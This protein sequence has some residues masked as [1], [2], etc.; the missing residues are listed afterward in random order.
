MGTPFFSIILPVYNV[1][2][3]IE[4]CLKSLVEQSFQQIEIICVID[5]SPDASAEIC[6]RFAEKDARVKIIYQENQGA[7]VARN[8]GIKK[9]LGEYLHFV[10]PDDRIPNLQVYERLY[11]V[12]GEGSCDVL[13]GRSNYYV[14]SFEVLSEEGVY[15]LKRKEG[16]NALSFILENKF[17]FALTSGANK[18]IRRKIILDNELYWP[19]NVIN[20]DDRWLPS[21]AAH[22]NN[23]IFTDLLIYDV[24]RRGGSL[25]TTKSAAHLARRGFGYMQTALQN[26]ALIQNTNCSKT[27][28]GNGISYYIQLYFSGYKMYYDNAGE[29]A[30]TAEIIPYLKYA[31]NKKMKGL[32]WLSG[33]IGKKIT[34]RIMEKRYGI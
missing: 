26:C 22:S 31:G 32:Y 33:I 7:A 19:L 29:K 1:E 21:I 15:S 20:E 5:G 24:R 30:S 4:E 8:T 25:T 16:Y 27:A 12:L 13:V 3:Y 2:Q 17:F 6:E 34:A 23:I 28:I 10:D 14:D 9:A 11:E 18:L